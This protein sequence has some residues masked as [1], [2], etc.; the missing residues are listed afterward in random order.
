MK[1]YPGLS[2]CVVKK[3]ELEN[4]TD[5]YCWNCLRSHVR[6][7]TFCR[8]YLAFNLDCRF[9][10]SSP[11]IPIG[12]TWRR[13]LYISLLVFF[14]LWA[15]NGSSINNSSEY[16]FL[17]LPCHSNE[18][19]CV[20]AKPISFRIIRIISMLHRFGQ[21]CSK[22]AR[23][24]VG[25]MGDTETDRRAVFNWHTTFISCPWISFENGKRGPK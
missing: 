14:K 22:H 16:F 19:L 17:F 7:E 3:T 2:S 12:G 4:N 24:G 5:L 18:L 20:L 23:S 10:L 1:A 21:G 6:N 8:L 9:V 11:Y 13:K 15:I 25:K